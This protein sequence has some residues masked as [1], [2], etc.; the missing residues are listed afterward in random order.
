MKYFLRKTTTQAL[1]LLVVAMALTAP[2]FGGELY[3][4]ND[5]NQILA[6]CMQPKAE[7]AAMEKVYFTLKV[8]IG[9]EEDAEALDQMLTLEKIGDVLLPGERRV[10]FLGRFKDRTH[11]FQALEACLE[12]RAV[13]CADFAPEVVR[14]DLDG[15]DAE[16]DEALRA[17]S[18]RLVAGAATD[19]PASPDASIGLQRPQT[20][21]GQPVLA[22]LSE[23]QAVAV[24][25]RPHQAAHEDRAGSPGKTAIAGA[26]STSRPASAADERPAQSEARP[27]ALDA[28]ALDQ[29]DPAIGSDQYA[30]TDQA[31]A[32]SSADRIAQLDAEPP[33]P[34]PRATNT[35]EQARAAASSDSTASSL[36]D[37]QL[38]A[39]VPP[40]GADDAGS[41]DGPAVDEPA[42]PVVDARRSPRAERS[43]R[44][45]KRA[46]RW[47]CSSCRR[48]PAVLCGQISN[49]ASCTSLSAAV[50]GSM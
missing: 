21:A 36:A 45:P 29:R 39:A 6:N 17:R 50:K 10:V 18:A 49:K 27:E 5:G 24:V 43:R 16:A 9:S 41:P 38:A 44:S 32:A 8:V 23:P 26:P 7:N 34:E 19:M 46:T 37:A 30:A 35:N 2:G 4:G 22:Q 25:E 14:I 3:C 33:S 13:K 12:Q 31:R 15:H 40:T 42:D 48:R 20:V 11:A 28:Q 47:D 1:G